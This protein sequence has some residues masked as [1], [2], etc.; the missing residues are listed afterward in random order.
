MQKLFRGIWGG[1]VASAGGPLSREMSGEAEFISVEL[2]K[3]SIFIFRLK[4]APKKTVFLALFGLYGRLKRNAR[5]IRPSNKPILQ[6]SSCLGGKIHSLV[7]WDA[8]WRPTDLAGCEV[9]GT[10]KRVPPYGLLPENC[11]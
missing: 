2:V 4:L 9:G 8:L 10:P 7:G 6:T 11:L 1:L 5:Y 3:L